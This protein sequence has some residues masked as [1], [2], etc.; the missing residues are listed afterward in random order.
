MVSHRAWTLRGMDRIYV[1]DEGRIVEEGRYEDLLA[2]GGRF[3][4]IFK[5]Q[6]G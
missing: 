2:A 4:E 3:A 5:E 1:F 6:A